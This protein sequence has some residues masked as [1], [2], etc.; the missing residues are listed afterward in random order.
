MPASSRQ[1][2]AA[3]AGHPPPRAA[4]QPDIFGPHLRPPRT[5][6]ITERIASPPPAEPKPVPANPRINAACPL[7][8][9]IAD[10]VDVVRLEDLKG[11]G[12]CSDR[13]SSSPPRAA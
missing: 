5:Q 3:Q 2:L 12:W 13:T 9:V 11:G 6:V 1:L 10:I 7:C 8:G 4:Y